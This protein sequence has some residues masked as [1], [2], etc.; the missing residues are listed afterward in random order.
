MA[1]GEVTMPPYNDRD[2]KQRKASKYAVKKDNPTGN[3]T[4]SRPTEIISNATQITFVPRVYSCNYTAIM[5]AGRAASTNVWGWRPDMPLE[6]F[7]DTVIYNYFYEHGITL[8]A[9]S[10]K[11]TEEQRLER[12]EA[13]IAQAE[14]MNEEE[15]EKEPAE[16]A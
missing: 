4:A 1:T 3:K 15:E 13:L 9:Y 6:N 16:V 14:V 5:Q 8:G 12:E 11:E 10:V 2:Q 7:L